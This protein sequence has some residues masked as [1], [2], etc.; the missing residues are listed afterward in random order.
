MLLFHPCSSCFLSVVGRLCT[1]LS[2]FMVSTCLRIDRVQSQTVSMKWPWPKRFGRDAEFKAHH[3]MH[4][5]CPVRAQLTKK[6]RTVMVC[7]GFEKTFNV[8]RTQALEELLKMKTW[9]KLIYATLHLWPSKWLVYKGGTWGQAEL[10]SFLDP[11]APQIRPQEYNTRFFI[12]LSLVP[13]YW[14]RQ[15][16]AHISTF[17]VGTVWNSLCSSEMI[18]LPLLLASCALKGPL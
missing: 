4:F 10:P 16:V 15:D 7:Q 13:L 2:R 17:F 11:S 5:R 1:S 3:A 12:L 14:H 18:E 9:V 8:D 6:A